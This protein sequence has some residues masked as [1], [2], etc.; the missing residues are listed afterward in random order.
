MTGWM[1]QWLG[2]RGAQQIFVAPASSLV[3]ASG[4]SKY[5]AISNLV[6][7]T[8]MSIGLFVSF[9][10]YGIHAAVAVLA[11]SSFLAYFVLFPAL[12]RHMKR[13]LWFEVFSVAAFLGCMGLAAV[14]PLPFR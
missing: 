13:A 6:R 3:L 4:D 2:F 9:T 14:I 8:L 11:F 7:F 5:P 12:A 10:R 1:L